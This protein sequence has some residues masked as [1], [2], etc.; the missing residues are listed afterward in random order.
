[1]VILDAASMEEVALVEL[2]LAMPYGLH[3][4]WSQA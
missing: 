4:S 1:L 2:P 3:G